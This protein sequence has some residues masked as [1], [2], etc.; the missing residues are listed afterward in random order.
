MD[1]KVTP[2]E[3]GQRLGIAWSDEQIAILT[4]DFQHPMLI[5]AVAGAG[6]TT[7]LMSSILFNSL[8]DRV[9]ADKVLGIT[10]SKAAATDMEDKYVRM[11]LKARQGVGSPTFKTF[12]A[13][14]YG[15]VKQTRPCKLFNVYK[16]TWQLF[17][18]ISKPKSEMSRAENVDVFLNIKDKLINL[19]YS[20]NGIDINEDLPEVQSILKLKLDET[21]L[22]TIMRYLGLYGSEDQFKDYLSVIKEYQ[23]LKDSEN[24]IDFLDMQTI[25]W[26]YLQNDQFT[27][28]I[29]RYVAPFEQL[30]LDEFQDISPLQWNLVR[31][32]FPKSVLNSMVVVGDD[33]QSIYSFRGSSPEII[34]GFQ[35]KV[36]GAKTYHLSTNYRTGGRILNTAA[37]MIENNQH[38]LAKQLKAYNQGGLAMQIDRGSL[39]V[40]NDDPAMLDLLKRY[41][42]HPD[43]SFAVL[44]RF[45]RDLMVIVDWLASHGIYANSNKKLQSH[46][47]YYDLFGLA[48]ALYHDDVDKF[49]EFS[50][51]IKG[52][53]FRDAIGRANGEVG[54]HSIE[55]LLDSGPLQREL[56]ELSSY[57]YAAKLV[58]LTR[59][60]LEELAKE[61]H[62]TNNNVDAAM[63]LNSAKSL[64]EEYYTFCTKANMLSF[65]YADY[66][67]LTDY[68]DQMVKGKTW[69]EFMIKEE[70][71]KTAYDLRTDKR[72]SAMTL[73]GAKGLEW[74]NVCLYGLSVVMMSQDWLD[75]AEEYPINLD[76]NEFCERLSQTNNL[77]RMFQTLAKF[78]VSMEPVAS[79][80]LAHVDDKSLQTSEIQSTIAG[81]ISTAD[82]PKIIPQWKSDEFV[83]ESLDENAKQILYRG[84]MSIAEQVEEERRLLY[85]GITRAKKIMVIDSSAMV[86]TP[87][88]KELNTETMMLG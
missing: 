41:N 70:N 86:D 58:S 63:V 7:T 50:N 26:H 68:F 78:H 75:L 15:I 87:L 80:I 55:E 31:K 53:K 5:N 46:I 88:L 61:K 29:K 4:S 66:L 25:V 82:N 28:V 20:D 81:L 62:K 77:F 30:Y 2:E 64:T 79:C 9:P 84:V 52:R 65:S 69:E 67:M 13:F 12:H 21:S 16:Y 38:R 85:V 45:N 57:Q 36:P 60:V 73:H 1:F 48:D 83:W 11:A 40:S 19:G 18:Q 3:L 54:A 59:I 8:N 37:P 51:R 35:D 22:E 74:D 32:L 56:Q 39:T 72:F 34:L 43:Q 23:A 47:L 76:Y 71:K 42:L 14:F 24:A 33:D 10:F 49:I 17:D 44:T 6:K 27:D